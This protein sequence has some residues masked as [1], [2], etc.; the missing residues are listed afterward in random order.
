[1]MKKSLLMCAIM[2]CFV[3]S[4]QVFAT[5]TFVTSLPASFG[6]LATVTSKVELDDVTG[7]Y[8]YTYTISQATEKFTSFVIGVDP[9]VSIVSPGYSSLV[10]SWV[11]TDDGDAMVAT[12]TGNLKTSGAVATLWF[13]CSQNYTTG[14]GALSNVKS[15]APGNV[16]VPIP[17]PVTVVLLG[18]GWVLLRAYKRKKEE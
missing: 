14:D 1:M 7:L 4:P 5:L 3:A 6:G 17:E 12:I 11:L 10:S 13:D 16:L 2:L 18:S 9:S 8:R 15:Y